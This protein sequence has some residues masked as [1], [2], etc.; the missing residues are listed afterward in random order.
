MRRLCCVTVSH[1]AACNA[2]SYIGAL[3]LVPTVAFSIQLADNAPG[4]ATY[5]GPHRWVPTTH[6]RG[7]SGVAGIWLLPGVVWLL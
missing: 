2:L 6:K 3:V 1:T 5:D 7:S 4:K